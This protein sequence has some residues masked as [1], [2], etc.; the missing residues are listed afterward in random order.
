MMQQAFPDLYHAVEDVVFE[1][2]KA[3]ARL[4]YSGIHKGKLFDYEPTG[5]RVRYVGASFF[6]FREGRI[7]QIWVLGDLYG[8]YNELEGNR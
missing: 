4:V 5:F 7:A 8:L 1:G 3:A 2:E 6:T